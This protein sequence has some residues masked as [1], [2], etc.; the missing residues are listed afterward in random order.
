MRKQKKCKHCGTEMY[1]DDQ[2]KWFCPD[3]IVDEMDA[4]F[5]A[6]HADDPGASKTPYVLSVQVGLT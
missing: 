2:E 3:C 6:P 1:L 4:T 5:L